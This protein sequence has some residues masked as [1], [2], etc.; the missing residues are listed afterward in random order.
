MKIVSVNIEGN[1]HLPKIKN[2]L[3][4]ER[5]D[6]VFLQEVYES[7]VAYLKNILGGEIYF[8]PMCFKQ[9]MN[10]QQGTAIISLLPTQFTTEYLSDTKTVGVYKSG[11]FTERFASQNFHVSF[12]EVTESDGNV[13]RFANT[14]LPVTPEGSV[15]EYQ[16]NM[17]EKL[18]SVLSSKEDCVLV[19]DSNA[20]RGKEAFSNIAARYKDNIPAT[21]ESS[22][23]NDL[24]RAAPLQLMVDMLFTSPEY[25]ATKVKVVCGVSDHCAVCAEV[26]RV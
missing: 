20:P 19:G 22:L 12:A 2:L 17:I 6:I 3:Q 1:K 18:L 4:L 11:T 13:Y 14:H 21:C 7:D 10:C 25:T 16:L 9:N 5:P 24:H 8:V 26:N 23:D 15:T